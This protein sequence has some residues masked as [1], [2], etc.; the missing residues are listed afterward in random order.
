MPLASTASNGDRPARTTPRAA[1]AIACAALLA[2]APGASAGTTPGTLTEC[3]SSRHAGPDTT[4]IGG[5][6]QVGFDRGLAQSFFASDTLVH[7]ISVWL[8]GAARRGTFPLHLSVTRADESGRPL[9]DERIADAGG[10]RDES[11]QGVRPVRYRYVFSPPLSLPRPG[12][13]AIVLLPGECG[14]ASPFMTAGDAMRDGRLFEVGRRGCVDPASSVRSEVQG[15]DL[16][17]E[18][19]YCDRG[20]AVLGRTWGEIRTRY[21]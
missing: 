19:E 4:A 18:I 15:R 20:T 13:Y 9:L 7:A 6:R 14:I 12:A 10:L 21:R 2:H 1:A 17:Y 11:G 3:V 8:P 5:G 16:V